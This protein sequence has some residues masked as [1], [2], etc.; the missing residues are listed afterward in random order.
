MDIANSRRQ[1]FRLIS[2]RWLFILALVLGF[3]S[4]PPTLPA[5]ELTQ[6]LPG[7]TQY[8]NPLM[9]DLEFNGVHTLQQRTLI[10]IPEN[11]GKLLAILPGELGAVFWFE[12][13]NGNM[14]NV[15]MSL[16]SPLIIRRK[17]TVQIMTHAD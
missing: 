9:E 6:I 7:Y 4:C 5:P 1:H 17:G 3:L 16:S 8:M 12:D 2:S 14:R 15:T 13:E 10:D 11:Y